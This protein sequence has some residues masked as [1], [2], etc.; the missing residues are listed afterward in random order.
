MDQ[1]EQGHDGFPIT[2]VGNDGGVGS[3]S[4]R[5]GMT[6]MEWIT[7]TCHFDGHEDLAEPSCFTWAQILRRGLRMTT[8]GARRIGPNSVS[9]VW[10]QILHRWLR[11]TISLRSIPV[12]H[13]SSPVEIVKLRFLQCEKIERFLTHLSTDLP[14]WVCLLDDFRVF[15]CH[16]KRRKI[17]EMIA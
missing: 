8:G 4:R 7:D 2:T 11:M 9:F 3:R 16:I 12:T 13:C 14:V 1:F 10:A 6:M 5:S 17:V 15:L